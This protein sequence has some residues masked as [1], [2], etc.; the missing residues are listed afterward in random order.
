MWP[1]SKNIEGEGN[2]GLAPAQGYRSCLIL[3]LKT[4][5]LRAALSILPVDVRIHALIFCSK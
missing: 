2:N 4:K 1:S 3:D 5:N